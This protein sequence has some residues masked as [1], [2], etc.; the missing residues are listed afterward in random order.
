MYLRVFGSAGR[1]ERLFDVLAA[2]WR[3]A[4]TI[5][6]ISAT[7]M[8]RGRFELDELLDFLNRKLADA[9]SAQKA[10]ST[11]VLPR[12]DIVLTLTV[13][14]ASMNSSA[15]R[16]PGSGRFPALTASSSL[17]IMDLRAFTSDSKGCIFELS[18]LLDEVPS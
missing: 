6:L 11:G 13:V 8:A 15:A 5:Q 4:G 7:D 2:S 18:V 9:T 3:H 16:T 12:F 14:T 10:T 17:V 1:A